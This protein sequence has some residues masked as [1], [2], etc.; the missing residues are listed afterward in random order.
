MRAAISL[1]AAVLFT[2]CATSTKVQVFTRASTNAGEPVYMMVRTGEQLE[3]EEPY[4]QA[5]RRMFTREKDVQR[6]ER[7][8]ILPGSTFT[9]TLETPEDQDLGIYFF[10]TKY[11]E[12]V[13]RYRLVV[14]RTKLPAAIFIE[15]GDNEILDSTYRGR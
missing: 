3:L 11:Q 14:S 9:V 2:G 7:Q 5:A 6:V 4:E 13:H 8:V 12:K 10:F 15:L 1:L